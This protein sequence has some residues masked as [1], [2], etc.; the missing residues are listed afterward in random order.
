MPICN[1]PNKLNTH[2]EEPEPGI[3]DTVS[4]EDWKPLWCTCV[5]CVY[6]LRQEKEYPS[7]VTLDQEESS[8]LQK[9]IMPWTT[10]FSDDDQLLKLESNEPSSKA[11]QDLVVVASLIDKIPNLGGLC[12]SC[13]IFGVGTYAIG[14]IKYC[15]NKEFQTLSVTADKYVMVIK[16][17][18]YF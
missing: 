13:E 11:C 14:S 9:K 3:L 7:Y 16:V 5:K 10:M 17:A 18:L 15:D 12:R 1:Q 2:K 8:N 4:K 6:M